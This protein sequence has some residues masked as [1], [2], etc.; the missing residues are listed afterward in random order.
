MANSDKLQQL[1]KLRAT[2]KAKLT[3]FEKHV[4][5]LTPCPSL[6]DL[7]LIELERRFNNFEQIYSNFDTL[8]C[9][10]EILSE[11]PEEAYDE[12][13]QFES[14]YYALLAQARQLLSVASP[15]EKSA[16]SSSNKESVPNISAHCSRKRNGSL[17]SENSSLELLS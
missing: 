6:S 15:Q 2:L 12:R 4:L 9:D 14:R 1:I 16:Q 7:Q 17:H 3:I 8:Q 13:E 11:A 10:I 5:M